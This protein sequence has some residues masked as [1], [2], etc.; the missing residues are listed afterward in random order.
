MKT[1]VKAI[2]L[3][4]SFGNRA[5][6]RNLT[7]SVSEGGFFIII[8]PNGSGKTTLMRI[9]AGILKPQSGQMQ[10]FERRISSF[11]RKEFARSVAFV[12]QGL[13]GDF[14]FT[15]AELVLMGRAPYNSTL[16][17]ETEEDHLVTKQAMRFT[18]VEHLAARKLDQLSG[19]EQQRVF[20]ARAICQ[21]PKILLLDEPTAS[22]DLAH[23]VRI[24]DLMER[25]K[26]EKGITIVMVSHDINLAAMYGDRVLLL[27]NGEIVCRGEPRN[28]LSFQKLEETYGCRLLVDESPLGGIPRITL[29]PGRYIDTGKLC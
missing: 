26:A 14:P 28:V 5:V 10:I 18:E 3:S 24:M 23:Q 20:I 29:V 19:G 22:L 16:G 7:F 13:P 9:I 1:A 15:V 11:K 25:L 2:N 21:E 6:L 12:P 27:K 4:H 8:G 17:I